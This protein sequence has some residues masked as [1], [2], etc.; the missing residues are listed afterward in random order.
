MRRKLVLVAIP[1]L[2]ALLLFAL[3]TRAG[4]IAPSG[5]FPGTY[6]VNR[7]GVKLFTNGTS[8]LFV[9][10]EAAVAFAPFVNQS[11]ILDAR[12]VEQIMNPGAG[13]IRAVNKV[14]PTASSPPVTLTVAIAKPNVEAG[15]DVTAAVTLE[16]RTGQ[17]VRIIPRY[18]EMAITTDNRVEPNGFKSPDNK[19]YW[20]YYDATSFSQNI[21]RVA[22]HHFRPNWSAE[23]MV[24]TGKGITRVSQPGDNNPILEMAPGASF[25]AEVSFGKEL[26]AGSYELF[27]LIT[28]DPK[29][30]PAALSG[31]VNF[32]VAAPK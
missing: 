20:Y 3:T 28:P 18:I 4:L 1:A 5:E 29:S 11:V 22:S 26:S 21:L 15:K 27:A 12:E 19:A 25:T 31:R 9:S 16:N 17:P 7:W 2:L 13:V 6:V 23:Q 24:Q 32:D 14:T 30:R 8:T 10:D